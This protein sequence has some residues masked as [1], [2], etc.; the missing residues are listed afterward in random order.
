MAA[1]SVTID[2]DLI[3][4]WMLSTIRVRQKLNHHSYCNVVLR[5]PEDVRL[6]ME[7]Y[8]GKDI[9]VTTRDDA[10]NDVTLLDGFIRDVS[11]KYEIY[12]SYTVAIEGVT[13]S[14][15]MDITERKA[16]YLEKTLSSIA[17]ELAGRAEL[18]ASVKAPE[19]RAFNYVQWGESDFSFLNRL[20]DDYGCWLRPTAH[21]IEIS[22]EFGDAV[23]LEWRKEFGLK[24]FTARGALAPA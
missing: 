22:D 23:E 20:A 4:E 6:P 21:G 9:Q 10:G 7:S 8:L 1:I 2:G 11:L 14:F 13:R 12:G 3:A 18:D 17:S 16:Y 5:S 19:M 15:K 24:E